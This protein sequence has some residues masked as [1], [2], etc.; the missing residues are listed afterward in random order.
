MNIPRSVIGF[1]SS[2]GLVIATAESCTAGMIASLL[3]DV[4]GS[5]ACLDVGIV[6]Y[7]PSGKC[8]LLNVQPQT[9]E[10]HGLTSEPVTRE[11]AA[12]LLALEACRAQVVV[13]NTGLAGPPPAGSNLAPG[14]QCFAW[15]YRRRNGDFMFS[16]TRIFRGDRAAIRRQ[17]ALYSLGRVAHYFDQ[18]PNAARNRSAPT[19]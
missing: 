8:G 3:A 19:P 16:E 4:P 18:L 1:L 7:S 12:G 9:I 17:A 13:A 14:T 5:G 2:R 10:T 11:M 15:H 6:V